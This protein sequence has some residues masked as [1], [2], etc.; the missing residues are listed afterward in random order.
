MT[1]I[2]E[3]LRDA[4]YQN[5]P[6]R[7]FEAAVEIERLRLS[8]RELYAMVKGECPSL[9]NEDS[10]GNAR[11]D[12]QIGAL[13]GQSHIPSTD[14]EVADPEAWMREDG[15]AATVNPMIAAGWKSQ[16]VGCVPLYRR[17][18]IHDDRTAAADG[19]P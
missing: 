5:A 17:S 11:L 14:A 9:L 12:A 16:G 15:S 13:L 7:C 19:A 4:S 2:I 8:L 10:G 6:S 3:R 1:D 18:H